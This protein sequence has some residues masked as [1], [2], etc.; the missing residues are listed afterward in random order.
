MGI[1]FDNIWIAL[2]ILPLV[3]FIAWSYRT[4]DRRKSSKER[5]AAILR[6]AVVV[7]LL[8]SLA[9]MSIGK[10]TDR[11]TIIFAVDLS[12]STRD[13]RD[14]MASFI[15]EAVKY[16]SA[17]HD[18]AIIT[19][20]KDA[21]V[22]QPVAEDVSFSG[23]ETVPESHFT[24]IDKGLQ[25]AAALMPKD[26]RKRVVLLTDG[27]QNIGDGVE[28][29]KSLFRQGIK[30]DGVLFETK[31]VQEVQITSLEVPSKLY[32][33][34]AYDIYV[35]VDSTY[36][37]SAILRLYANREL[38]GQQPVELQKG[39]NRF[40]FKDTADEGGIKTYESDIQV[41]GDRLAQNNRVAAYV[42]VKGK[43]TVAI[44]E[45]EEGEGRELNKILEAS[46]ID[47]KLFTP[48]TLPAALEELRKYHGIVLCD[49]AAE[50]LKDG[51]LELLK[52]YVRDLGRGLLVTGGD[53]SFALGGYMGTPL[54]DMLPVDLDLVKKADIPSLGLALVIDR[55]SSMSMGQYGISKIDMAKEAA[56]RSME[57][58]RPDDYIGVIAFD[59]AAGW[60]VEMQ[61]PQDME[62][63]KEDILA[64]SPG[65]GTN[66]YP[67]LELAYN[68]LSQLN[69]K[70]KH[71]I[72]LT[73]GQS[74]EGDFEGIAAK[75]KEA[76]ITLSTVAV[77][78]DADQLLL[79]RLAQIGEGRYYFTDEFTN[80]PKIF[81]KETYL[82]T[83]SYIQNR[84]FY[85]MVTGYS[86][87]ISQFTEGF[88]PLH[89][90]IATLP[91]NTAQIPLSSDRMDPILAEW[92]YG[93][94]KVVA[95]TSDL[96]GI[97][98]EDWLKWSKSQDFWLN[99]IS[100]MLPVD[101]ESQGFIQASH[102]GDTGTV[103]VT[104][105]HDIDEALDS[106][107]IIVGPD[108]NEQ[109][110]DMHVTEP[111][112]YK[113]NFDV[114]NPGVYLVRVEQRKDGEIVNSLDTALAVT[115][116]PEYDIRQSGSREILERIVNQA[117]GEI[118]DSPEQIFK[119][120]LE[121][122]W[123]QTE[124]WPGMLILALVLF[125]ADIAIR[126]LN[127]RLPTTGRERKTAEIR[128]SLGK[129]SPV[130]STKVKREMP[131]ISNRTS[132]EE[133]R[134]SSQLLNAKKESRRRKL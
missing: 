97:W 27:N 117:G 130:I 104:L 89:G 118:L 49:V 28:R 21:L 78:S 35:T 15:Q 24:N 39:E 14:S 29:A 64:I 90:Y 122:V 127:I 81:T 50:D 125:V 23:F 91:K 109:E 48:S 54:E 93:L 86:P 85:P 99:I 87:V 13:I 101:E 69:T 132:N 94:G 134:L 10:Y 34:E 82:A 116:S 100:A 121:P 57:S 37:T 5:W 16:K 59:G 22:E 45:G 111:G 108:G 55:S 9:G 52:S 4:S 68:S 126:R 31:P 95:W 113:G 120:D 43:P 61:K 105:T 46:N 66:M 20:G 112:K 40:I 133:P 79:E 30:V 115:Y 92:Q 103:E 110:I 18:I 41:T 80:I 96:R 123:T 71:V 77:G 84:S 38:I 131:Q 83:Q 107:A 8:L 47:V 51:K 102:A 119:G 58:L 19:F 6:C 70:L 60:V 73:D 114:S 67:G 36:N 124:I 26:S 76:N 75:M 44:V 12:E 65:G 56:L 2:L 3:G 1:S 106:I 42:D 72:L 129:A 98:T 63:I 32:E 53:N 25:M 128:K 11:T 62:Q 17:K 7:L 74:Q 33:G 88:P